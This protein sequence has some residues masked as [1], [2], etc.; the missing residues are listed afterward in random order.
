MTNLRYVLGRCYRPVSHEMYM[1]LWFVTLQYYGYEALINITFSQHL[2]SFICVCVIVRSSF[3]LWSILRLGSTWI[4]FTIGL[5]FR[6][7]KLSHLINITFQK[8]FN[9]FHCVYV[10]VRSSY[11]LWSILRYESTWNRFTAFALSFDQAFAS[12][13][14]YISKALGFVSQFVCVIV[15]SSFRL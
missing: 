6:S 10:I 9:S 2:D 3:R 7:I 4:V 1:S 14:Y 5:R 8:H 11:R 15:R 12:D 13:Q